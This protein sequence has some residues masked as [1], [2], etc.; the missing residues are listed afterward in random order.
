[1]P[2]PHDCTDGFFH[3]YWRRPEAYLDP[4]VRAG[5]SVFARLTPEE[6]DDGLGRLSAD[7]ENG[8]WQRRN[9]ALLGLEE[10]DLG[11]RLVAAGPE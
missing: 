6:V 4:R 11:Y 2:I 9:A 1:V 7:L 10:L 8:E 3:A 5:I